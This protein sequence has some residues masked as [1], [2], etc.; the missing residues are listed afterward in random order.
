MV[1]I[2]LVNEVLTDPLDT[3]YYHVLDYI[4]DELNSFVDFCPSID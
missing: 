3:I 1:L 4:R 2:A